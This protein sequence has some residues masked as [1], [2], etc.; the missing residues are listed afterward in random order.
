[1]IA[2]AAIPDPPRQD[3]NS[4]GQAPDFKHIPD[5]TAQNDPRSLDLPGEKAYATPFIS[6]TGP[7]HV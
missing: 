6:A 7:F 3:S 1:M 4:M 5:P 2:P